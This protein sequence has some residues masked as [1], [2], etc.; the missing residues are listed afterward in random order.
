[1][2]DQ[3]KINNLAERLVVNAVT[4][5]IGGPQR[6]SCSEI[7][8]LGWADATFCI[9]Y[10]RFIQNAIITH[11]EVASFDVFYEGRECIFELIIYP[12]YLIGVL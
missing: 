7:E 3:S 4:S 12:D 9:R 10:Q 6:V 2:I 11:P 1:M 8:E 5:N